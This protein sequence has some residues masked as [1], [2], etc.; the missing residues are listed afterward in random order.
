VEYRRSG[1]TAGTD[2]RV[3]LSERDGWRCTY[4]HVFLV[5]DGYEAEACVWSSDGWVLDRSDPDAAPFDWPH[6][7]HVI[8]RC[9]GGSDDIDNLVLACAWCNLRK[10][11]MTGDEWRSSSTTGRV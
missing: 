2:L 1:V 11:A 3:R 5:R 7:D 4:C 10:G 8:P 9:R 6:I